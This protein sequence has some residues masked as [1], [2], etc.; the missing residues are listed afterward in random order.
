MHHF[1]ANAPEL[2]TD[3]PSPLTSTQCLLHSVD[4]VPLNSPI[5][6][7]ILLLLCIQTE[8]YVI[9]FLLPI[10]SAIL[11]C[12]LMQMLVRKWHQSMPLEFYCHLHLVRIVRWD[13]CA[14][15]FRTKSLN[16][17]N[18]FAFEYIYVQPFLSYVRRRSF[19]KAETTLGHDRIPIPP[20][21][22][23]HGFT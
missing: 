2:N 21:L 15:V 6:V 11:N 23:I 5:T 3:T 12:S 1:R 20:F 7:G 22:M 17:I 10:T 18:I 4:T 13:R 9:W 19:H 16:L 8:I 14:N